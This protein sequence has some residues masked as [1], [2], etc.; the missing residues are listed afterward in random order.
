MG[1][2]E[3][4]PD[5]AARILAIRARRRSESARQ[6][7]ARRHL[8]DFACYVDPTFKPARHLEYIAEHLEKLRRREIR[9]LMIFAPP[10]HGKSKLV[11]EMFP[12][13]ALGLD[14]S[15]QF[16]VC[17]HT[18]SLS[19]TFSRNVRNL[20]L[21]E[22]YRRLF[23]GTQ[24]SDDSATIQK[25]TL[26]GF[27][28]PAMMSVGVG[29]VPTGHG[30]KILD[31]DDPIGSYE[32]AESV[33]SRDSVYQWYTSTIR[34][35]L[36]PKAPVI[37]SM[38]RWH[39]DDLAGRL[40]RDMA[41]AE[42]WTV[43]NLPALAKDGDPLGRAPGM[44]LW[45]E[46]WPI[47]ELNALQSVSARSFAAKYQQEPRPAEGA[48]FKKA[49]LQVTDAAPA[50]LRWMR[51]YDLAYSMKQTADS[52]ASIACAID[53]DGTAYLRRGWAGK[54]E[55]PDVRRKIKETMLSERAGTSHGVESAIHGGS[56]VQDLMRDKELVGV[57]F[58]AVHVDTDKMVRAIP[59]ADRAESGKVF[60]VR[61][62]VN[63]DTW[64]E[65]WIEEM[66][67]FPYGAHD[68]R[69]DA[70][71]GAFLMHAKQ[72]GFSAFAQEQLEQ[73]AQRNQ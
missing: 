13:W 12:A 48:L 25:W 40:L 7:L 53:R 11:S 49:W 10:R 23:P 35:R 61:E 4:T 33:K 16:M 55:S 52:T 31:I 26:D 18:S 56:T 19:D 28:R 59:L 21:S 22:H 65:P 57:S 62:S 42:Q 54:M 24:L 67:A 73:Y 63:D 47:E 39:E 5:L 32:D 51:Y 20:I 71:S 34:P 37:L 58:R 41:R 68:D 3:M 44:P 50:G 2:P 45:P 70:A 60:F 69:V 27:T 36:E 66:A 8:I 9:R 38:Q 17:S 1:R 6:E 30:A 29:G 46:W 15:E 72:P 14:R 43:I 64:I